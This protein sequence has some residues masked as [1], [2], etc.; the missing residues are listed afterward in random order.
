MLTVR[1]AATQCGLIAGV[2]RLGT[3]QTDERA[4]LWSDG[5]E[6]T[7]AVG[8]WNNAQ[9]DVDLGQ[10]VLAK[11][12]NGQVLWSFSPCERKAPY[13]CQRPAAPQGTPVWL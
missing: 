4:L 7:V 1:W 5:T 3:Q 8:Y 2:S 12:D 11:V 6:A 10:C 9:P 13:V